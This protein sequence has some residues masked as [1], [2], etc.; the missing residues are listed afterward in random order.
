M[1]FNHLTIGTDNKVWDTT[2][3]LSSDE[4]RAA[5]E[6]LFWEI[7]NSNGKM[8][9]V[10][11][12]VFA[13]GCMGE[14]FYEID[15]FDK[16]RTLLISSVGVV[17]EEERKVTKSQISTVYRAMYLRNAEIGEYSTPIVYDLLYSST[18]IREDIPAYTEGFC[19]TMGAVAFEYFRNK[20]K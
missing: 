13:T 20:S 12:G 9:E 19:R 8:I 3:I 10:L 1:K 15:L 17:E 11:S 4:N 18:L 2:K 6:T 7:M 5:Y 14:N 16:K